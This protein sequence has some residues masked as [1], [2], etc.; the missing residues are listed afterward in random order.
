MAFLT[1]GE[2]SVFTNIATGSESER[3][4]APD[5]KQYNKEGTSAFLRK[6]L[7]SVPALKKDDRGE[8]VPG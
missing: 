5:R 8:K 1:E 2:T 6:F 4:A 7:W 3:R